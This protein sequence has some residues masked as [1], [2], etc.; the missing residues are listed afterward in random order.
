MLPVR[1]SWEVFLSVLIGVLRMA[2]FNQVCADGN[3]LLAVEEI[4]PVSA[5]EV[6][7]MAVRM[8]WHLV[9]IRPFG[10]GVGRM[11]GGGGVL[12]I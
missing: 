1:I 6:D 2:H 8:V 3:I 5:S 7:A 4:A 12:L 10:V 9:R 11:G